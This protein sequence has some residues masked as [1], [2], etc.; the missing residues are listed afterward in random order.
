M[1]CLSL[2]GLLSVII[3]RS[4]HAAAAKYNFKNMLLIS[5]KKTFKMFY[6]WVLE[7]TRCL[8]Y[9]C[10]ISSLIGI[11]QSCWYQST[12]LDD[13]IFFSLLAANDPTWGKKI[14]QLQISTRWSRKSI[15]R[16]SK[17]SPNRTFL[18]TRNKIENFDTGN[19]FSVFPCMLFTSKGKMHK[20]SLSEIISPNLL[21][22]LNEKI[23]AAVD[24][25]ECGKVNGVRPKLHIVPLDDRSRAAFHFPTVKRG[26]LPQDSSAGKES[27]CNAGDTSSTPGQEGPLEKGKATHSSILA[28]RSPWIVHGVAKSWTQL[29]DFHSL[30]KRG[31]VKVR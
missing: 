5:I 19:F 2:S 18:D 17:W 11:D 24:K 16:Q 15:L 8:L 7:F 27:A 22:A 30:T 14:F 4:I 13:S 28:W 9:S 3:S 1:I 6:Y 25:S 12:V 10:I 23:Q 21:P 26:G 31:A 20:W 29:S